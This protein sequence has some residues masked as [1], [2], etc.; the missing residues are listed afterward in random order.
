MSAKIEFAGTTFPSSPIKPAASVAYSRAA[1][2]TDYSA[3][4]PKLRSLNLRGNAFRST[5]FAVERI[6]RLPPK[7]TSFDISEN[8]LN[9]PIPLK[10]FGELNHLRELNLANNGLDD[11]FFRQTAF[12]N[13]NCDFFPSLEL[14]D[15]SRNALDS[16]EHLEAAL[17]APH[18]RNLEYTGIASVSLKK[19]LALAP[20]PSGETRLPTLVVKMADNFLREEGSRRKAM[21]KQAGSVQLADTPDRRQLAAP[22]AFDNNSARLQTV[23][24][25]LDAFRDMLSRQT[26]QPSSVSEQDLASWETAVR[27]LARFVGL[28]DKASLPTDKLRSASIIHTPPASLAASPRK[29]ILTPSRPSRISADEQQ[30]ASSTSWSARR[31]KLQEATYDWAP[32]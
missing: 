23:L 18:S 25:Q 3:P 20:E 12:P 4:L 32:L 13:D 10:L 9:G 16:L 31:R 11:G 26:S 15:I 28:M 1:D 19:Y 30:D 29:S 6:D 7:L 17:S 5:A 2:V 8:G 24:Q 27:P 21:R 22:A 14:L